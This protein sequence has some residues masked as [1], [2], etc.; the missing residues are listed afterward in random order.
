MSASA[1]LP[2]VAFTALSAMTVLVVTQMGMSPLG[3][4]GDPT[5]P[6]ARDGG[7]A[8]MPPRVSI[9]IA[10]PLVSARP[11]VDNR[12]PTSVP[13]PPTAIPVAL[14]VRPEA[15]PAVPAVVA[16]RP[17]DNPAVPVVAVVVAVLTGS[18]KEPVTQPIPKS[19]Q[20]QFVPAA[21]FT[22]TTATAKSAIRETADEPAEP[23]ET[24]KHSNDTKPA[25]DVNEANDA[26]TD[27]ACD[28][29]KESKAS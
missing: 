19:P 27:K 13:L 6:S 16:V 24:A 22:A 1:L 14:A 2:T 21:T 12:A 9:S 4:L 26:K 23:A 5:A 29:A 28:G 7:R 20:G 17:R 25:N 11:P 10:Q 8:V 18:T 15:N 3:A